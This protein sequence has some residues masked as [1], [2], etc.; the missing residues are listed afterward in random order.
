MEWWGSYLEEAAFEPDLEGWGGFGQ[1]EERVGGIPQWEE[2]GGERP[3]RGLKEWVWDELGMEQIWMLRFS[4]SL[5]H[6][7]HFAE[8]LYKHRF[9]QVVGPFP[10]LATSL[11]RYTWY[12]SIKANMLRPSS[13][14]LYTKD[15]GDTELQVA[16][17][18]GHHSSQLWRVPWRS[19][20][21]QEGWG[22]ERGCANPLS[23][24]MTFGETLGL[25]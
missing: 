19:G 12:K 3:G 8:C 7:H 1:M 13:S 2:P 9:W 24:T 10:E 14:L 25:L 20:W 16:G 21:L 4:L 5:S 15:D 18:E 22:E 17:R 23:L 6:T 11:G